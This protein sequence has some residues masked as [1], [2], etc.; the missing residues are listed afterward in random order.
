MNAVEVREPW[1]PALQCPH[2]L[3]AFYV[4]IPE[5]INGHFGVA[6]DKPLV[7]DVECEQCRASFMMRL[8]IENY[9]PP[10]DA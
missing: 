3:S 5:G 9:R 10:G 1:K 8:T 4:H 7:M 6:L 2:C